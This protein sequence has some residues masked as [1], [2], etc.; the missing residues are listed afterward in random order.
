MLGPGPHCGPKVL[1]TNAPMKRRVEQRGQWPR[2]SDFA[3]FLLLTSSNF[4]IR[5]H[6]KTFLIDFFLFGLR[7]RQYFSFI[8]FK[9]SIFHR[10][11]VV[12]G[13]PAGELEIFAAVLE[14]EISHGPFLGGRLVKRLVTHVVDQLWLVVPERYA[15]V[16]RVA[17]RQVRAVLINPTIQQH[18]LQRNSMAK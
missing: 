6:D 18:C 2:S 1:D 12:T 4:I 9:V 13:R 11:P 3:S 7:H 15:D 14:V 10:R 17:E 8:V 16:V 5:G